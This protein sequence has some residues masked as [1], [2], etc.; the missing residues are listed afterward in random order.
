MLL[1]TLTF[2]R[3]INSRIFEGKK[4]METT[5]N[6]AVLDNFQRVLNNILS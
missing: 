5:L 6:H 2:I 1:K 3:Q 4:N